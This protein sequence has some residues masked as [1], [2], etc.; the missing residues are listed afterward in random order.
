VVTEHVHDDYYR[1]G[2]WFRLRHGGNQGNTVAYNGTRK[3]RE[4]TIDWA[5][6]NCQHL[7][8]VRRDGSDDDFFYCVKWLNLAYPGEVVSR[9]KDTFGD[10]AWKFVRPYFREVVLTILPLELPAY[11]VMWILDAMPEFL[12]AQVEKTKID[13]IVSLVN[14]RRRV[15]AARETGVKEIKNI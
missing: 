15:F 9:V 7:E 8:R 5:A 14:S 4:D 6:E 13:L 11:V 3:N 10:Q 2:V 12:V 1:Y